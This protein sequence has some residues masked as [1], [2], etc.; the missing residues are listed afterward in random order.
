MKQTPSIPVKTWQFYHACKHHIGMATV[1]KLFKVSPRQI[2][3]WACDPDF[4]E[5][6]Q[7]NPMDR[8][9]TLLKKLME[10][11]AVDVARSVVDRQA[12]IVGCGLVE[13]TEICP[14]KATLADELLDDL[15]ALADFHSAIRHNADIA[16]VR[17]LHRKAKH[18]LDESLAAYEAQEK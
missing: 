7:R 16:I 8:Y 13:N 11:G 12:S 1:Q 2:D 10:L 3:R 15:P 14:D 5:S 6:S 17:D 9:E 18:D 4:A